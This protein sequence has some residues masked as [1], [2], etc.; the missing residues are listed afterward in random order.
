MNR[1]ELYLRHVQGTLSCKHN[2]KTKKHMNT[3]GQTNRR[4]NTPF[5][6][7]IHVCKQD[8]IMIEHLTTTFV[9]NKV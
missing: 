5:I 8:N 7:F 9:Q 2:N 3:S 6:M 1:T 4:K